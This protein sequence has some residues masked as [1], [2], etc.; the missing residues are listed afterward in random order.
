MQQEAGSEN[1][2]L[3]LGH[4]FGNVKETYDGEDAADCCCEG[5]AFG[6]CVFV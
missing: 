4:L 2:P 3:R 6:M 5:H 1:E